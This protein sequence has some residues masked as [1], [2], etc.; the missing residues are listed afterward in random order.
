MAQVS[1][2]KK[3]TMVAIAFV[4]VATA[5]AQEM[6]PAPSPD[7]GAA[8]SMTV[9]SA[10]GT[11]FRRSSFMHAKLGTNPSF[12]WRS[13]LEGRKVLT[14]GIRWRVGDGKKIDIW[15]DPWIPRT[16]NFLPR[17]REAEGL[18]RVS[19]LPNNGQ[20]RKDLIPTLFDPEDTQRILAMPLSRYH[21]RDK[22]VWHH[23]NNGVYLTSLG[24][25]SARALKR[26]GG[27]RCKPA[28]ECS[29]GGGDGDVRKNLWGLRIPPRVKKIIWSCLHNI[30]PTKDRLAR[31]GI[32]V[33]RHCLLC[34]SQNENL[35]HLRLTCPFSNRLW[36]ATPWN[37]LT[38]GRPRH[39]FKEWWNF[40]IVQF[41]ACGRSEALGEIA[42]IL[43]NLWKHM[44]SIQFEGIGGD[45]DQIW[46]DFNWQLTTFAEALP[47]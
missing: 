36:F 18:C 46:K 29:D 34:S 4:A 21:I 3:I 2:V 19:Q 25:K 16:T 38:T 12:K 35:L 9:S 14:M 39:S 26:N 17:G 22:I 37:I 23:T 41:Q 6:A 28:G 13:L 11:Y 32:L 27:L 1:I 47:T 43:W 10:M 15:K 24:Y 20:W 33:E 5:S 40:M 30:L 42:C 8:F 45:M 31:K 7:A 44:N